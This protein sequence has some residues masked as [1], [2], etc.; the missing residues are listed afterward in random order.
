MLLSMLKQVKLS[1]GRGCEAVL[2]PCPQ[3]ESLREFIM[4]ED[5]KQL[6]TAAEL[7]A[8]VAQRLE[9]RHS[10]FPD[11]TGPC[12]HSRHPAVSL[13]CGKTFCR[14]LSQP[15]CLVLSQSAS[16][17]LVRC[18]ERSGLPWDV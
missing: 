14:S 17:P 4:S 10:I 13:A 12:T 6:Q 16:S 1:Q 9:V 2:S 15:C 18:R 7:R 3:L 8:C 11:A 5:R